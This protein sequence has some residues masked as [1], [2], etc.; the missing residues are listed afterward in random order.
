[1]GVS[2]RLEA[3]IQSPV[4]TTFTAKTQINNG[5]PS[6]GGK[7]NPW[8]GFVSLRALPLLACNF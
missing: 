6:Q 2:L 4:F 1:M 5:N 8:L 3:H 7:T